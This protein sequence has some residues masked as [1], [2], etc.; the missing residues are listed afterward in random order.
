MH[1]PRC[2]Y[3]QTSDE[4]RFCTKCGLEI[5]DVKNLLTPETVQTKAQRRSANNKA[6]R[7]GLM[8]IF[9]GFISILILAILR[10]FFTI[11]QSL[12]AVTVLIFI[13]GG[14]IRM[15]LP[16]LSGGKISTKNKD[17]WRKSDLETNKLS[18]AQ[19]FDKTL[20]EAEYRPPVDFGAGNFDT[21]ELV[22]LASV[23]E[24]TTRE[25]E[26]NFQRK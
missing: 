12:F 10:D 18:G 19:S 14:A 26:N 20:P 15:A 25:L 6:A 5:S 2:G 24:G 4:I 7:Q 3:R 22:P 23:T 16:S 17:D 8:L 9:A 13:I 11:P 21:N 1:C